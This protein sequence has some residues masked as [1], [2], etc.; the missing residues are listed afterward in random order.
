MNQHML[1]PEVPGRW[2]PCGAGGHVVLRA[3]VAACLVLA[4]GPGW[5]VAGP[6]SAKGSEPAA[7]SAKGSEP[8]P[9]HGHGGTA[10]AHAH[11]KKAE[12]G[13]D[14]LEH[15][16]DTT[17]WDFLNIFSEG[18][19]LPRVFGLQITKYMVLEL[20]TAGLIAAIYIPLARR[21]QSGR[22]PRGAFEGFF[23][24]LLVF[25][26]DQIAKPA[27]SPP[28]EEHGGGHGSD[29]GA[30]GHGAHGHEPVGRY[31]YDRY[32]PFLWTLFLFILINN[33]LGV[34]PF[35][36]S[37]TASIYATAA[38]AL[39]A[40]FAIHGSAVARM[41]LVPYLKSL[42]PQIDVPF[43][44]GYFITPL[45][46]VIELIG[47]LVRNAVLAVRLFA[48]MFAGHAVLAVILG[49]I[50]AAKTA[51]ALWATITVS[52]I[53][54]VVALTLLEIFVAALQAYIFTFLAALFMGMAMHP[55]H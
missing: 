3:A 36:G 46:F 52:S 14:P 29:H 44:L 10:K 18:L 33:L 30:E 39:I 9:E 6:Q 49:F 4:V 23:E 16:M 47:S 2:P 42:W 1:G 40:F 22:P 27:L 32:V 41:G 7:K 21:L 26:R 19:D 8:A 55:Q 35:A 13:A 38:L 51:F 24:V 50:V 17:H 45:V 20:I 43:P 34:F 28:E 31:E 48:N 53:I 37:A 11:A 25:V 15:V 54:G 12:H 5:A